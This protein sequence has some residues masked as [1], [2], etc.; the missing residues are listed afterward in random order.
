MAAGKEDYVLLL[1]C[2]AT[3]QTD[4]P[5]P[6]PPEPLQ[7]RLTLTSNCFPSSYPNNPAT[8]PCHVRLL[9]LLDNKTAGIW[10]TLMFCVK[11]CITSKT[12]YFS[13]I[14]EL[15]KASL[16]SL[17]DN[18][19]VPNPIGCELTAWH[20]QKQIACTAQRLRQMISTGL[21]E[22]RTQI[23][24]CLQLIFPQCNCVSMSEST[25]I[26]GCSPIKA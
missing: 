23:Q 10:T 3:L 5:P 17:D 18:F 21:F 13:A 12:I 15:S 8:A 6:P 24:L 26:L 25:L 19:V 14:L 9:F 2:L 4:Q 22:F 7:H 11:Y 16:D 20:A 1:R